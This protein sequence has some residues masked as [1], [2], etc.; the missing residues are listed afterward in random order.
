[1]TGELKKKKNLVKRALKGLGVNLHGTKIPNCESKVYEI[2]CVYKLL[3][4]VNNRYNVKIH[5]CGGR[6]MRIRQRGGEINKKKYAYFEIRTHD[7]V[8]KLEVHM[9]IYFYTLSSHLISTGKISEE[10]LHSKRLKKVKGTHPNYLDYSSYH[11]ID[12]ILI[13]NSQ[14]TKMPKYDDIIIGIECKNRQKMEKSVAR[15]VLGTRRELSLLS[16]FE[17]PSKIDSILKRNKSS[18]PETVCA[19]P[20]SLFWLAH[21]AD[22]LQNYI[23]GPEVYGIRMKNWKWP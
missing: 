19:Y 8:V 15:E 20:G 3:K 11:E 13:E 23:S 9:N 2:Y 1:M 10:L 14:D 12:I 18:N 17:V 16:D 4:W 7:D 22:N 21:I 5:F 6:K